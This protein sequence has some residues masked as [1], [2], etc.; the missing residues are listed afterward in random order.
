MEPFQSD[1]RSEGISREVCTSNMIKLYHLF[2]FSE[3]I[4]DISKKHKY[5]MVNNSFGHDILSSDVFMD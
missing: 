1:C 3:Y 5:N 2:L 4:L